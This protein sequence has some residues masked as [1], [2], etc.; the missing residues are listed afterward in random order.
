MDVDAFAQATANVDLTQ[1]YAGLY[2]NEIQAVS[3]T[4]LSHES[5]GSDRDVVFV[6][7]KG[8]DHHTN[9]N[10]NLA[11]NFQGLNS[12][13]EAFE[14]EMKANVSAALSTSTRRFF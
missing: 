6:S 1:T 4:I 9:L 11:T 12:A 13:L 2:G 10:S 14:A 8:W 7:L 5:R 3:Q